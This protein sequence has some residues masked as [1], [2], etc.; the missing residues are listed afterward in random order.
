M[1]ANEIKAIIPHRY[2]ILL[3]DRITSI[4]EKSITGIKNISSESIFFEGHFPG[5]PIFPGVL[6]IEALAQTAAVFV[7]KKDE[8]L[9]KLI[10]FGSIEQVKFRKPVYPGDQLELQIEEL[11]YR[12]G[13]AGKASGKALV[14]GQVVCEATFTFVIAEK[15]ST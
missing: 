7:L 2:P 1:D 6:Q 15:K 8:N 11:V 12:K 5:N 4:Q 14:D 3:V 13:R 10:Y 9:G